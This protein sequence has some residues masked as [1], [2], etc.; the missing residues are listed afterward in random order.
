MLPLYQ[1]IVLHLLPFF[2]PLMDASSGVQVYGGN[3]TCSSLSP[4]E[5]PPRVGQ[6]CNIPISGHVQG[7]SSS[8]RKTSFNR[9]DLFMRASL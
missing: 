1:G 6:V 9:L 4:Q 2:R 5:I 8:V 7:V 3:M